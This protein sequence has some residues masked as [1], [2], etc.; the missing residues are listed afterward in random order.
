[1]DTAAGL[2]IVAIISA[3]ASPVVR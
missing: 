3:V 1:L 2:S